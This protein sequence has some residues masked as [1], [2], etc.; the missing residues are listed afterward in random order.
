[1][2]TI[3]IL[4]T[5]NSLKKLF[6]QNTIYNSFWL[7]KKT[8][9][10]DKKKIHLIKKI[11]RIKIISFQLKQSISIQKTIFKVKRIL[12]KKITKKGN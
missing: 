9:N 6:R 2:L 7:K 5:I 1:M 3:K 4:F 10:F 12:T 11:I 8:L